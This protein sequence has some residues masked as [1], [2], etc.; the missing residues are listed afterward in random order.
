MYQQVPGCSCG[1]LA[2]ELYLFSSKAG[3]SGLEC[4]FGSWFKL[5]SGH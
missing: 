5:C 2:L 1:I 4:H 3:D